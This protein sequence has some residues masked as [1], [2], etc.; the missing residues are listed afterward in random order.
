MSG[1]LLRSPSLRRPPLRL[2]AFPSRPLASASPAAIRAALAHP[3]VRLVDLRRADASEEIGG[4]FATCDGALS[5]VWDGE[6]LTHA[7]V[8]PA[9]RS[10]PLLLFCR[11]GRRAAAAAAFLRREGYAR[12]L[13]GGGPADAAAWEAYGTRR[14]EYELRGLRQLLDPASHTLSYL[15]CDARSGEALL[16]DPVAPHAARDVGAAAAAGVRVTHAVNTH[17][18][19]DHLS[20]S[21]ELKRRV[22]G[23]ASVLSAESG[24]AADVR[25][26]AGDVLTWGGGARTLRALATPGHTAGCLSFY[27]EAMQAVFTGDALLIEG[28]G[29]T[30][31]Q[32]GDARRL[33]ESVHRE[34]FTLPPE[35]LVFPAHDYK[36]RSYSTVGR[37]R[38]SNPRL[39]LPVEEFVELM[40]NLRLPRPAM[41]DE[42]VP[43]NLRCGE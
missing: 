27:D 19:A 40:A 3:S 35:T 18:H 32:G 17:V 37:E 2:S 28:C 10:T 12:A 34:L 43:R 41:M 29:R 42:V 23:V 21:A 8:L 7:D 33:Y 9:D 15:L 13:C 22:A 1:A 38:E 25:L 4:R 26:R 36:G 5:A 20:G 14:R 11:S 31:F 39:T 30:D 16:L 6:R 24:G